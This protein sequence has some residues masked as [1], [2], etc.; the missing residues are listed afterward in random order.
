MQEV[1]IK[2]Y[3]DYDRLLSDL[4]LHQNPL[5]RCNELQTFIDKHLKTCNNIIS[6]Q[7]Y[8]Y[9]AIELAKDFV[10]DYWEL[11]GG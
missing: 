4:D 1:T 9:D 2:E 10:N 3:L 5:E 6:S 8:S 7:L 11:N